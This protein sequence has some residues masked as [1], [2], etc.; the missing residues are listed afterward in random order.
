MKKTWN[1]LNENL[2]IINN[3]KLFTGLI[4]ICLNI[5]S[6]F[7]TV[8]LSPSQEEFM[9]NYVAREILIFAVCWMG[10]RD[11]L[12]SI[13]ITFGFYIVTEILLHEDSSMCIAPSYLKKIKDSLDTDGDGVI[14]QSEIDNAIKLLTKTK[15]AHSS[16]EKDKEKEN[17]FKSFSAN[18]Y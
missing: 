6:K 11:I 16:K 7:I 13:M 18:K 1:I 15:Q 14:S 4:M 8:K 12:T 17:L 10:T 3:S 2:N 5:G 9:K